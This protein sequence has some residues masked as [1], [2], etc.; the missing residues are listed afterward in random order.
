MYII[1]H[2]DEDA[3]ARV[4]RIGSDLYLHLEVYHW[5]L[6]VRKKLAKILEE[7]PYTL[8]AAVWNDKLRRFTESFGFKDTGEIVMM[9][10]FKDNVVEEAKHYV[11]EV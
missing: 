10:R 5:S 2:S 8:H 3:L 4:E 6:G 7:F 11:R 9:R 1:V